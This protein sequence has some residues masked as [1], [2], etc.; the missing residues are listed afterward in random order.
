[1]GAL[2]LCYLAALLCVRDWTRQRI[3]LYALPPVVACAATLIWLLGEAALAAHPIS[4]H[5]SH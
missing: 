2:T 1:M 5:L 3:M 4:S